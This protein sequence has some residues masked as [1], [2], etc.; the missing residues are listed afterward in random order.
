MD[1]D[2]RARVFIPVLVPV[3]LIGAIVVFAWSLSRVFLAVP[4]TIAALVALLVALYVLGIGALVSRSGALPA[5]SLGVGM[6]VGLIG[7]LA[8][9]TVASMAGPREFHTPG[10]EESAE[11]EGDGDGEGAEGAEEVEI[12]EDAFVFE[13]VDIDWGEAP[14]RVDAGEVTLAILN[15][16]DIVHNLVIEEL[17]DELVA[18]APGGEADVGEVSLTAGEDYTYYCSVPGHREAGMEGTFTAEG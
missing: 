12:P 17:G 14:E 5:R 18:E 7:V 15:A 2:F 9:G 4:A 11:E 6:A 16:G 13:A 10:E 1:E 8:A 3:G